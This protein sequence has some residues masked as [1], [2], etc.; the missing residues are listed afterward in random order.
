MK[1]SIISLSLFSILIASPFTLN[2]CDRVKD[3]VEDVKV[4]LP[5]DV[6]VSTQTEIP[7]ASIKTDSYLKYPEIALNLDIDAAIK[8]EYPQLSISNLKSAQLA[9]MSIDLVNSSL[10]GKLDAV[11]NAK[12]Y[13]KAPN[14]PE[15]L[16]AT[17]INNTNPNTIVFTPEQN[18]ELIEY[19]KSKENSIILEIQ[20]R[21]LVLDKFTIKINPSFRIKVGV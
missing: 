18:V 17:V 19:F 13:I 12:L 11:Q 7:F 15:K 20:G 14:L 10:G 9:S 4:P 6:P 2:S 1:K 8:K 16:A 3:A 5:F 21:K